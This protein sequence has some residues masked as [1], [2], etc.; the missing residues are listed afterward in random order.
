[1]NVVGYNTTTQ[2]VIGPVIAIPNCNFPALAI[3]NGSFYAACSNADGV[4][5]STSGDGMTWTPPETAIPGNFAVPTLAA[6]LP[7]FVV[8][9]QGLDS[10][11]DQDILGVVS[12]AT[13]FSWPFDIFA[14]SSPAISVF[15]G[16]PNIAFAGNSTVVAG[17]TSGFGFLAYG[18]VT[19]PTVT[20][21]TN[22]F[23]TGVRA[24]AGFEKSFFAGDAAVVGISAFNGSTSLY[25]GPY[26]GTL[27]SIPLSTAT[28][29]GVAAD[30]NYRSGTI[31]V[32]TGS[33]QT[34]I[35]TCFQPG[36]GP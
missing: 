4:V 34:P 11:G 32:T 33:N 28:A 23:A 6:G 18:D 7:G 24:V 5:Y 35:Y 3:F 17:A 36:A 27:N 13:G 9:G 16:P 22:I 26:N 10:D 1:M 8:T 21:Q 2:T 30:G 14:A 31:A 19:K 20:F 15:Y 12:N 29:F 25:Q